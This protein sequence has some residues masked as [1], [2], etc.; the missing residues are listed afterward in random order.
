[1]KQTIITNTTAS[2]IEIGDLGG[3]Y[4]DPYETRDISELYFVTI[5]QSEDLR[6]LVVAGDI[7]INDGTDDMDLER[8]DNF[9][10]YEDAQ[11]IQGVPVV[12]PVVSTLSGGYTMRYDAAAQNWLY[13]TFRL[14]ELGDVL[15]DESTGTYVVVNSS[16]TGPLTP[17]NE[18]TDLEDTPNYYSGHGGKYLKVNDS[19]DGVEFAESTATSSGGR[20]FSYNCPMN[21]GGSKSYITGGFTDFKTMASIIFHGTNETPVDSVKIIASTDGNKDT[22]YGRVRLYDVTNAQE[23]VDMTFYKDITPAIF[24]FTDMSNLPA[25]EAIFDIQIKKG[26]KNTRLYYLTL[27]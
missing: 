10:S 11:F 9:L 24:T 7:T 13:D 4:L 6:A 26:S 3:I 25:E 15:V 1:M 23:V 8:A 12:Q 5:V 22:Y 17:Y 19:A 18:F 16:G 20:G 14:T 21:D 27:Y 2:G